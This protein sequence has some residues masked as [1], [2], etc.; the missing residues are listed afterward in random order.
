MAKSTVGRTALGAAVCRLMEQYQPQSTRL[1]D[2][3]VVAALISS[4]I[5]FLMRFAAVRNLT[6]NQMD[7]ITPGIYGAQICRT[8][9]IDDAVR[10]A[11][12]QGI[13]Q[14]VILGAGFDSRPYRLPGIER[15][16]VFEVDLP[17][18]QD[19]KKKGIQKYLGRLPE[20]VTFIPIDF[21]RQT[22]EEAFAGSAF[23]PSSQVL[24]K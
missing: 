5:Q 9:Y 16:M 4:P 17:S 22:L 8:R 2:D 12:S 7:R 14:L 6:I 19:V 24:T 21:D 20:Y 23:D 13:D 18:V 1:F 15:V 10:D 3:P 11:L